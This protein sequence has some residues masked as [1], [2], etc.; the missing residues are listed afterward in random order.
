MKLEP[1]F[2]HIQTRGLPSAWARKAIISPP[3]SRQRRAGV[4]FTTLAPRTSGLLDLYV[5]TGR[6]IQ[7]HE[8]VDRLLGRLKDVDEALVGPDLE[9]LLG[10]FVD[11]RAADDGEL[12][13][14]GGQWHG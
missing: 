3:Q 9:L 14:F 4:S 6:Q 7:A 11:E 1:Q 5:D 12:L 2:L 13:D 10:V 8:G